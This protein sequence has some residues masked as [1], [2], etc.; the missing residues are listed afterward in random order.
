MERKREKRSIALLHF[1]VMMKG[2]LAAVVNVWE[3][4]RLSPRPAVEGVIESL[5]D[6]GAFLDMSELHWWIVS[7]V[8][9][10]HNSRSKFPFKYI[11]NTLTTEKFPH[12]HCPVPRA[13]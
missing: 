4:F 1:S 7:R 8:F 10:N 3:A 11:H 2:T 13:S 12:C 5:S 6:L 9:S